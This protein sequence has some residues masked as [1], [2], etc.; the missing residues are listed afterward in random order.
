MEY[1]NKKLKIF[2]GKK[3]F[4][5]IS[6]VILLCLIGCSA[7]IFGNCSSDSSDSM[8]AMLLLMNK[9]LTTEQKAGNLSVGMSGISSTVSTAI[10]SGQ[11]NPASIDILFDRSKTLALIHNKVFSNFLFKKI[12]PSAIPTL[13]TYQSGDTCDTSSCTST[14][15]GDEDCTLGGTVSLSNVVTNMTFSPGPPLAINNTMNGSFTFNNCSCRGTDFFNY[16][17]EPISVLT[18]ALSYNGFRNST[19][20][21]VDFTPTTTT[22]NA[23]LSEDSTVTSSSLIING[24]AVSGVNITTDID[25]S[26]NISQTNQQSNTN[27]NIYTFSADVSDTVNGTAVMTGSLGDE[28]IN[29]N[30]T[31]NNET[32]NYS[33]SCT[34][35][36]VDYT[37]DCIVSE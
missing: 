23:T 9:P 24:N 31:F 35:N 5:N 34:F 13:I 26:Q 32:F 12:L 11:V 10:G 18:G 33:I 27:G 7:I 19:M 21:I 8:K 29:L 3:M 14:L 15:N 36:M 30:K 1:Y 2:G 4:K 17:R 22:G 28:S 37:G 16:P 20:E 6:F 25:I